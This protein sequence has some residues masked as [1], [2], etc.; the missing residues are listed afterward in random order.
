MAL[1][2]IIVNFNT[3]E[4][5]LKCLENLRQITPKA[6][7]IVV[8]SGSSDKSVGAVKNSFPTVVCIESKTNVGLAAGY[9]LGLAQA[10][11]DYVL[12]LGTD[13]FPQSETLS[14]LLDFMNKTPKAGVVTC[15]LL[16]RNGQVDMDAHRGFPSP[17]V[18]LAHFFG[19]GKLF[20]KSD[21]FNHYF[22]GSADINTIHE[23]D[24]CISHFMLVRK[25]TL[26]EVG[27]MDENFFVYG[28]DVDFCYRV[29]QLGWKI[30]YVPEVS[31]LHYK[32]A[33]VGVR[34][35]TKDVTTATPVTKKAMA[36]SSTEAMK[37]FYKKHYLNKYPKLLTMLLFALI[38]LK[39]IARQIKWTYT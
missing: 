6:Q 5:L 32:G 36:N 8:D 7:I 16:L 17:W 19:F 14:Y 4:I 12:L 24:L 33:S 21:L 31:A 29:K 18:A 11:G 23:I 2:I 9:N 22:L 38:D 3:K 13:A 28:E 34:K 10:T 39:K 1:S 37:L 20:P 15:K 27:P 35:E 25:Q 30:F 26:L